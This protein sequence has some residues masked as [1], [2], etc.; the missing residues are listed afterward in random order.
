MNATTQV[1]RTSNSS[2]EPTYVFGTSI[3]ADHARDSASHAVKFH[4][5]EVGKWNGAM[6]NAYAIPYRN[7]EQQLLALDVIQNYVREFIRYANEHPGVT[8]RIA[9]FGCEKQAYTDFAISTLFGDAPRNCILPGVWARALDKTLPA[10]VLINDPGAHVKLPTCQD[11]LRTYFALNAPLWNARSVE[12]VSAGLARNLV[13]NDLA[14]K[15]LQLKHHIVA[16]N[17]DYYGELAAHASELTAV[18]YATHLLCISD[19]DDTAHPSQI[20]LITAAT[21][22]GLDI[23]QIDIKEE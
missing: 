23:D 3:A 6:G 17:A 21:R 22:G 12:L 8:F 18:W 19:F 13:A 15:R 5:A 1:A 9:R 16:T 2:I 7:S 10:R 4:G 20:S 14:A 11:K